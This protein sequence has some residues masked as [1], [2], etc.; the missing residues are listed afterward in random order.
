MG[1]YKDFFP[2]LYGPEDTLQIIGGASQEC[3][4]AQFDVL[5]WN[6]YKGRRAGW[7][8]D[9]QT[10]S[11][12]RDLVLLQEAIFNSPFDPLFQIPGRMEWVLARSHGEGATGRITGVKTGCSVKSSLQ[13][14]ILSEDVEPVFRTPKMIVATTY[15]VEGSDEPLLVVNIHAINFVGS[16]KFF[17]QITQLTEVI[18]R[19]RGPVLLGG[20]FNTWNEGRHRAMMDMAGRMGLQEIPMPRKGRIFHMNRPLDHL[21][22]RGLIAEEAAAMTSVHSSDHFPLTARLRVVI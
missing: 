11:E 14:F 16:E 21:F 7:D 19:H 3:L 5:I 20:D 22:A 12:G 18:E 1:S 8:R 9:F 15:P 6:I 2:V 17:R 4:P 13:A 10:L